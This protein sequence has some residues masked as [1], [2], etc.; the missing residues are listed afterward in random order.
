MC[1]RA[2]NSTASRA[3]H[4]RWRPPR[5]RQAGSRARWRSGAD[6][7]RL[8]VDRSQRLAAV[9]GARHA[10]AAE[11]RAPQGPGAPRAGPLLSDVPELLDAGRAR[12]HLKPRTPPAPAARD[13]AYCQERRRPRIRRRRSI[14]LA[15]RPASPPAPST[16]VVVGML[17]SGMSTRVVTPPAAAARVACSKPSQSVRPGSLMWTCVSTSPGSTMSVADVS[18]TSAASD[19]RHS[20]RCRD[21]P[22]MDDDRR[23]RVTRRRAPRARRRRPLAGCGRL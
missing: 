8:S 20:P 18:V 11:G 9:P 12:K 4:A 3:K 7:V 15:P 14:A 22:V 1:T 10:P 21:Q 5:W 17:L 19:W 2:P 13:R 16:V 23:G 6:R